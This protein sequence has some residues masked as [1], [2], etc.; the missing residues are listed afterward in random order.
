MTNLRNGSVAPDPNIQN[1]DI[2]HTTMPLINRMKVAE[3]SEN[4]VTSYVSAIERLF[5]FHG[6][7][8]PR[9]LDVDEVL[10]FLVSLS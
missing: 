9:D 6:S 8:H 1:T 10:D 7:I 3:R 4:T 2:L 5:R